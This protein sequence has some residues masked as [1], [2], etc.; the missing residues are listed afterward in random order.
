MPQG[1][2]MVNSL[3]I[4]INERGG[5]DLFAGHGIGA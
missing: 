5:M 1:R 2:I 4:G 3:G